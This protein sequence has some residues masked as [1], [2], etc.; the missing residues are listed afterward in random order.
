MGK[1]EIDKRHERQFDNGMAERNEDAGVL[2]PVAFSD[3]GGGERPGHHN[4]GKRYSR[5]RKQKQ[6]EAGIH[7]R[8]F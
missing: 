8:G 2:L 1:A 4:T 5:S 6:T 7:K 3:G